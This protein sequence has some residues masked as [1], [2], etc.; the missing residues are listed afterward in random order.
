MKSLQFLFLRFDG[1]DKSGKPRPCNHY[2]DVCCPPSMQVSP[3]QVTRPLVPKKD[4]LSCGN[5][6]PNGVGFRITGAVDHEAM[7]GEFPWMVA[8]LRK[9]YVGGDVDLKVMECGASIIHKQVVLTAA[10]CVKQ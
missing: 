10:H 9:E 4:T 7:Y 1:D 5:R 8:L 2:L 6:N 3:E